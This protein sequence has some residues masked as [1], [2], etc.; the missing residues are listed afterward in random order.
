V[1]TFTDEGDHGFGWVSP[2]PPWMART[3]H[4]LADAGRVWLVDP[5]DFPELEERA[6]ARGEPAAVIQ[7]VPWH[8]RDCAALAR[9]LGV[10]HLVAPDR[11][12]DAPFEPVRVSGFPRWRETALWW[13]AR[14]LL[15]TGE[16]LGTVRYYRA[17]GRDLGIHPFLRVRP[18]RNLA[19]YEPEHILCGHG[20][21]VHANATDALRD[22]LEHARSDLP[23]M[24]PRVLAAKRHAWPAT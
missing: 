3:S 1:V 6:R 24:A 9:R 14:R 23:A 4:A 17:P 13:P 18:P 7:T 15:L 5:V 12:D 21:G 2:E 19:G 10:P 11:L 20:S 8:N 16:A 22:A